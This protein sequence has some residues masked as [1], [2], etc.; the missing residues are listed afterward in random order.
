[1]I[2]VINFKPSTTKKAGLK[3][4]I[5]F[6]ITE[7]EPFNKELELGNPPRKASLLEGESS[8]RRLSAKELPSK[9]QANT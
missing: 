8:F 4:D 7:L 6:R 9:V 3:E 2:Q 5:S 1:M